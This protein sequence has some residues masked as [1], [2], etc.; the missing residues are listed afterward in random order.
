MLQSPAGKIL[1]WEEDGKLLT[2][3]VLS[4]FFF[5]AVVSSVAAV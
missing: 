3:N 2:G 1:S 5:S 4:F